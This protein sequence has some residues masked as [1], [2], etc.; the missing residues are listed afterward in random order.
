MP[1]EDQNSSIPPED[2][3]EQPSGFTP[4]AESM[5][6]AF[7]RR[8]VG[9]LLQSELPA[10]VK[11]EIN[12]AMPRL[13]EAV[14]EGMSAAPQ[15]QPQTSTEQVPVS[16]V[17]GNGMSSLLNPETLMDLADKAIDR[18]FQFKQQSVLGDINANPLGYL[19]VIAQN[20]PQLMS[21]YA[22]NPWGDE[23]Q[24]MMASSYAMGMKTKVGG[25]AS[26]KAVEEAAKNG[27]P[28]ELWPNPNPG[29]S[30]GVNE[31]APSQPGPITP[32]APSPSTTPESVAVTQLS[33]AERDALAMASI[34]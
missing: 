7:I 28:I 20:Q 21:L 24:R 8:E 19:N 31:A 26:K 12:A 33:I 11:N 23:F 6:A 2:D 16:S 15:T 10:I 13:V 27:T 29:S 14:K 3:A 1:D 9:A 17:N 32:Q 22:P 34:S 30:N 25:E 18:Y 5:F 4:E